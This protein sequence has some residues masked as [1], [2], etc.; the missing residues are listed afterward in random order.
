MIFVWQASW[1]PGLS[2]EQMD[3]ALIRRAGWSFPAGVTVQG[4]YWLSRAEPVV[5][6]ILE[7][8]SY[9]PLFEMAL[10]WQDVFSI[11]CVP[12]CTPEDGLAW[13]PAML[14]RRPD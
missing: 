14:E 13:G 4:E 7:A 10:T 11:D 5:V 2:R 8:D 3:G 6:V 1:K 12:A 9:E